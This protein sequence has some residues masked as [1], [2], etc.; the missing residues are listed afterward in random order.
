MGYDL[1]VYI[2]DVNDSKIHEWINEIKRFN[3]EIEIHPDFSFSNHSGFLPF[4]FIVFDCPNSNFNN[5]ELMSGFELW[6][7]D[8]KPLLEK[9]SIWNRFS[10]KDEKLSEIEK[11]MKESNKE[12][13]FMASTQ[14]SFEYRLAWYSAASLTKICDGI[15]FDP[16]EGIELVG[17][18]AIKHAY[19]QVIRDETS[20]TDNDWRTHEFKEWL[21]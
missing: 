12:I 16:Q 11:K 1:T 9:K 15:L 19:E 2:K 7:N 13:K 4:K 6:I 20:L 17:D 14:D 3:M 8:Y 18:Q 10:R 21:G 5:I